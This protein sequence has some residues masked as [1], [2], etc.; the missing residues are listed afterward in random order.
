MFT[1]C[2]N[3]VKEPLPLWHCDYVVAIDINQT[4][5]L[6][7]KLRASKNFE[8]LLPEDNLLNRI[9]DRVLIFVVMV[10]FP[11]QELLS[12]WRSN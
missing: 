6:V 4:T 5:Q 9:K 7:K 1:W 11:L 10:E 12:S 2:I 8:Q 3:Q